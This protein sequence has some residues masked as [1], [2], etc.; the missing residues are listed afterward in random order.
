MDDKPRVLE[1]LITVRK[2]VSS[3]WDGSAV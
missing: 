1:L 2:L 3:D